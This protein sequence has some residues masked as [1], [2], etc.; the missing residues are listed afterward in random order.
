MLG[1][2]A[3][4]A[5]GAHRSLLLQFRYTSAQRT[6]ESAE[7]FA[8]GLFDRNEVELPKPVDN[9]P[10]LQFDELCPAWRADRPRA[11]Q[12]VEIFESGPEMLQTVARVSRRLG[13]NYN[14]S[15]G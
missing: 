6:Q 3:S 4:V 5:V 1:L 11:L 9:D 12:E 2:G 14:L 15:M 7:A 13:F 8:S 10:L